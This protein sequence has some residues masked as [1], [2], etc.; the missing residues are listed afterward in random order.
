[1]FH[2]ARGMYGLAEEVLASQEELCCVQSCL[3]THSA[4]QE[5]TV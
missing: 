3:A 2:A 4:E 1:V 5:A